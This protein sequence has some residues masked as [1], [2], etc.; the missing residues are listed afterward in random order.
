[1]TKQTSKSDL[2]EALQA[3]YDLREFWIAMVTQT[4]REGS[5]LNPMWARVADVLTK[6]GMNDGSPE[7]SAT[8]FV[9]NLT[10]EQIAAVLAYEGDDTIG[11]PMPFTR[12]ERKQS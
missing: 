1:M 5:H 12:I 4:K 6:H 7:K 11:C 8:G 9:G 2:I 10:T 3:L